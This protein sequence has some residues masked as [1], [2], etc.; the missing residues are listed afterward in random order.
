MELNVVYCITLDHSPII[1]GNIVNGNEFVIVNM[2]CFMSG[3]NV[4]WYILF[5]VMFYN[6]YSY[7]CFHILKISYAEMVSNISFIAV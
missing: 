7:K 3:L 5:V 1:L 4:L 2:K 6:E